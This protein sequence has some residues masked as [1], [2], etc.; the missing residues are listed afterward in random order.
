MKLD[1]TLS[2]WIANLSWVAL[3]ELLSIFHRHGR[4]SLWFT[5]FSRGGRVLGWLLWKGGAL[6]GRPRYVE[7]TEHG[8]RVDNPQGRN[9]E[10]EAEV[11]SFTNLF[12]ATHRKLLDELINPNVRVRSDRVLTNIR[13]VVVKVTH[14]LLLYTEFVRYQ[15]QAHEIA[16]DQI[17][18]VS[19][20]AILANTV[21]AG[22]AGHNVL[23]ACPWSLQ[24]SSSLRLGQGI[25]QCLAGAL[26]RR[27]PSSRPA[28]IGV[29][30][31]WG[32][33][34]S[35]RLTDL[36]WWWESGIP[37]AR[38]VLYF[39]RATNPATREVV[40]QAEKLGIQC[41]VVDRQ[42]VGDSPHLMW[43]PAPG[44]IASARR[45]WMRLKIYV[46]GVT[47]GTVGRW[48]ACRMIQMLNWGERFED[49]MVEFNL[50]GIC[51]YQS[52]DLDYISPA[53]DAAGAARIG[54][55]WTNYNVPSPY[56]TRLHHVY[57]AWGP[58]SASVLK[59]IGSCVDHLLL[60]GCIIKG[61]Y[62][63]STENPAVREHRD[64]VIAHGAS[65]VLALYDTSIPCERFYEF[66]LQRVL[67]DQRWGLLIKPKNLET[68]PWTQ[69][70]LPK[71]EDLY[72]RALATGRVRVLS[73]L[74]TSPAEAAASADFAVGVGNNSTTIA[75]ALGGHRAIHLDYIRLHASSF[76]EW[77]DLYKAG[78]DRLVFDDPDTLWK[79]LNSYFDDPASD[80][81]LGLAGDRLLQEIDPFRDGQAGQRI[82]E[83]ICWFLEA[84]DRGLDRDRALD[85][86][87][88]QYAEKWGAAMVVCGASGVP[89]SACQNGK[90][91]GV[92]GIPQRVGPDGTRVESQAPTEG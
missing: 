47:R 45:L 22:W 70:R 40:A 9:F 68:T 62:R 19:S 52:A 32:L 38:I 4:F 28:S 60:S 25:A 83:Y 89:T 57:F 90:M 30:A 92:P 69:Q 80:C 82:G 6:T 15:H 41:V 16:T 21:P 71:L 66:F 56:H 61:A 67:E 13:K 55:H 2:V 51:N 8:R 49:F 14:D 86:A 73:P 78:P 91:D 27:P 11:S 26:R 42:A 53:C 36:F 85:Q 43:R 31:A 24:H 23:F 58:R 44:L 88:I 59:A 3:P 29:E 7:F 64:H 18:I 39:D 33:D 63:G 81:D 20:S 54:Y 74:H 34:R 79:R 84:L 77:A 12:F 50:R 10:I 65:R 35:A 87:D 46:W 37:N 76:S 17:V 1:R 5:S 72:K 48:M 75:A